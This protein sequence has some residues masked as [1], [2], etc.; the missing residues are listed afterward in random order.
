M[1]QSQLLYADYPVA[2]SGETTPRTV[3][4]HDIATFAALTGDYSRIHLDDD[5]GARLSYG[6]R[7]AHG[8]LSASWALGAL[9]QEAGPTVGRRNP[10]AWISQFEANYSVPVRPGD[11]LRC[12][13][14]AVR[15]ESVA[16][17]FGAARTDFQVISQADACVTDGHLLLELPMDATARP[18]FPPR[19]AVWP[20]STFESEPG[21]SY[22]LED[23]HPSSL[24]GQTEA[25]TLTEADVVGYGNFTGDYG[26]HHGDAEAAT[27]GLF[28][29]R[30]VQPMLAFDIG[31]ALWLRDWSRVGSPE[32]SGMAGH[33]C[34][35]WNFHAP[36]Y[37]GDTLRCQFRTLACRASRTRAG[38]GLVTCGLQMINQ[39]DEVAMSSE[40]VLM[41]PVRSAKSA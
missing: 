5:Y 40:V 14:R 8:L 12:R 27:R 22:Y 4:V 18:S 23:L 15:Q 29:A 36:F 7:I 10:C 11:T 19:P 32:G 41:Y 9:S 21:R 16:C 25:R 1:P 20:E 6:G 26:V 2:I 35:R 28:G 30:T 31:F 24:A 13:W 37:F 3:G 17:G 38:V 34:D 33:L 39:R